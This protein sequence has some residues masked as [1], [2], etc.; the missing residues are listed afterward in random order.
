MT[1]APIAWVNYDCDGHADAGLCLTDGRDRKHQFRKNAP[2][3]DLDTM[4][5]VGPIK[6]VD[7]GIHD[8]PGGVPPAR[9]PPTR[10][11]GKL[12][13]FILSTGHVV[14]FSTRPYGLYTDNA[15]V[16]L[17]P[18]Q[19]NPGPELEGFRAIN[20][21]AELERVTAAESTTAIV[22]VARDCANCAAARPTFPKIREHFP[23]SFAFDVDTDLDFVRTKQKIREIPA[24]ILYRSGKQVATIKYLERVT[25]RLD[26]C[27][28]KILGARA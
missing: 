17:Y 20:G 1:T 25:T 13:S 14:D 19:E 6:F 3:L 28:T 22:Y 7:N 26:A 12:D 8:W 21:S 4:Q 15:G 16:A 10:R 2:L 23:R 5:V 11:I 18:V 27:R 24:M 9:G